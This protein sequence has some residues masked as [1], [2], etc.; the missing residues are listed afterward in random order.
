MTSLSTQPIKQRSVL[1]GVVNGALVFPGW[2]VAITSLGAAFEPFLMGF[3]R[4]HGSGIT[5][6][7]HTDPMC[8]IDELQNIGTPF[9]II[10]IDEGTVIHA[11][12]MIPRVFGK[13]GEFSSP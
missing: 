2:A 8:R 1:Y 11:G 12:A 9:D 3:P 4:V 5:D 10:H 6:H 13:Q 7:D